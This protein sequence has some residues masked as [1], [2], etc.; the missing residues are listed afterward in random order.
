M[1]ILDLDDTLPGRAVMDH[2]RME[3]SAANRLVAEWRRHGRLKQ[4]LH[5]FGPLMQWQLHWNFLFNVIA[6]RK[7]TVAP[8]TCAVISAATWSAFLRNLTET[9]RCKSGKMR[10]ISAT[11][12]RA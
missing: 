4:L 6:H 3:R 8:M 12:R 2:Q 5:D 9:F 11:M 7:A 1:I 10:S